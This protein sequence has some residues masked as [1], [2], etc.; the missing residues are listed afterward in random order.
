MISNI[1]NTALSAQ[2]LPDREL[3]LSH[4]AAVISL[5]HISYD[6]NFG[7]SRGYNTFTVSESGFYL[8]LYKVNTDGAV[9]V[10]AAV[11]KNGAAIP[12]LTGETIVF[13]SVGDNLQL[14]IS[15][16]DKLSSVHVHVEASF[17]IIKIA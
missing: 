4:G 10:T 1:T 2:N 5:P 9:S 16:Q 17:N 12:A 7:I 3:D 15:G 14:V 11:H 13:L 8:I 6:N